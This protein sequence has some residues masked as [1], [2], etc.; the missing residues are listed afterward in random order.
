MQKL[1]WVAL[2]GQKLSRVAVISSHRLTLHL[3]Q[4]QPASCG[5]RNLPGS[6]S[7]CACTLQLVATGAS[8]K[9]LGYDSNKH[10]LSEQN[11]SPFFLQFLQ[12]KKKSLP[13]VIPIQ[14]L[15]KSFLISRNFN[16]Q[17][18]NYY[19]T[20]PGPNIK[21]SFPWN[22][23]LHAIF[24]SLSKWKRKTWL[25]VHGLPGYQSFQIRSNHPFI[26]HQTIRAPKASPKYLE[27]VKIIRVILDK[28]VLY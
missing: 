23:L 22:K 11:P 14:V 18:S 3:P 15:K 9:L 17:D 1:F 5:C 19:S 4:V 2:K 7:N 26:L 20:Q 21:A 10:W 13:T 27:W 24:T 28:H 25:D 8:A 16:K 12:I 6:G